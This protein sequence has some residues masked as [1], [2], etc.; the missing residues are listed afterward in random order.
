MM[1]AKADRYNRAVFRRWRWRGAAVLLLGLSCSLLLAAKASA[2][3][4]ISVGPT[5]WVDVQLESGT[6][7]VKTWDRP[8]VQVT[9][10]GRVDVRHVDAAQT[11]PRIP[12]QYTVWSQTVPTEHGNVSMPEESFVLP[13]LAGSSHDAVVAR[14]AG[15]TTVMIPRG[16]ALVTADVGTG[17]FN[18]RNYQG[19]FIAHVADGSVSLNRVKGS[20]YVEALRGQVNASNSTFD[21]L[22]ARTAT[23]NMTFRGCT[24]HQI[25]ASS[26]YGSILYDNGR[27]QP[28]LAH[29]ESVHGNVALG[30]RGGAQI[31]ARSGSGHIVSSFPNGAQLRGRRSAQATVRGGGPLVTAVSKQ[32]TVYIYNGSMRAHPRVQSELRNAQS[33]AGR[34]APPRY[35]ATQYQAPARQYQAPARQYQAPA[36]QYQQQPPRQYQQQPPRQYQQQPPRQYQ[37]QPPRQYQQ[38]PPQQRDQRRGQ[39]Q[40][41]SPPSGDRGGHHGQQPPR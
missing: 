23:G 6:L 13:R 11:D 38:Q 21:R 20:G 33:P 22:R 4:P 17:G 31:G 7:N 26:N 34:P 16:T 5:P 28:G 10:N 39:P 27:F 30:V 1:E 3:E 12:R 25:E 15:D 32:G 37:Q 2:D 9:T 40:A 8:Q 41:A 14:G 18:L 29:F 35:P 36:R 24:S 19:A